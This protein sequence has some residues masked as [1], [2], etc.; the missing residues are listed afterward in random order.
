MPVING[1]RGC[2]G[3]GIFHRDI[4]PENLLLD[5]K[6]KTHTFHIKIADF[7]LATRAPQSSEF[8]CGSLRY[9]S[10]ECFNYDLSVLKYDC[11][12]ND[13]WSSA[14]VLIN[15]LTKKVLK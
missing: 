12:K 8:G 1:L 7:G 14:I 15:M 10:Q 9:M 11:A 5:R 4:K 3:N 13:V 2:H 6:G